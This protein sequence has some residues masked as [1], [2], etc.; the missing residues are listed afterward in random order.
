MSQKKF[1]REIR[2]KLSDHVSPVSDHVWEQIRRDIQK[3]KTK[4]IL[5]YFVFSVLVA[6]AVGVGAFFLYDGSMAGDDMS[7]DQINAIHNNQLEEKETRTKNNRTEANR[8]ARGQV[9]NN[10]SASGQNSGDAADLNNSENQNTNDY[11]VGRSD[12]DGYDDSSNSAESES[13]RSVPAVQS[14]SIDSESPESTSKAGSISGSNIDE[15]TN[16]VASTIDSDRANDRAAM[17]S[18]QTVSSENQQNQNAGLEAKMRSETNQTDDITDS[19]GIANE[20]ATERSAQDNNHA[21][22]FTLSEEEKAEIL[23]SRKQGEVAS[24]PLPSESNPMSIGHFVYDPCSVKGGKKKNRVHC[25]SFVAQRKYVF[26]D[27]S[28]GPQYAHQILRTK[29]LESDELLINRRNT[30]S[31][32]FAYNITARAGFKLANGLTGMAGISLDRINEQF[33]YFDPNESRP[34]ITHVIRDTIQVTADS[35]T[36]VWEPFLIE[37]NGQ[38]T[39]KHSN[40]LTFISVPLTGG[41]TWEMN[42]FNV[43]FHGGVSLNLLFEQSGRIIAPNGELASLNGDGSKDVYKTSAGV[44]L[45]G[46]LIFEYNLQNDLSFIVEPRFNY[47]MSSLTINDYPLEQNYLNFGLNVGVRKILRKKTIHKKKYGVN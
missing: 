35:V 28:I 42:K 1:D 22:E 16:P 38:R 20:N 17:K 34:T 10:E 32:Q 6:A 30:E 45:L 33:D 19:D 25:Y 27:F 18:S 4:P 21:E 13:S 7:A 26:A 47:Q 29:G 31:Y 12:V 15:N 43:G 37:T 44:G 24:L 36:Y 9:L 40:K 2:E 23:S 3:K 39:V 41:Y 46:G 5:P 11:Q 14:R 8:G